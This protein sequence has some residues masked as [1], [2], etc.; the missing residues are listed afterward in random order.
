MPKHNFK[1][2]T[3]QKFGRL[4]VLDRAPNN[5]QGGSMWKCV[6]SCGSPENPKLTVVRGAELLR[7]G[8]TSCGCRLQRPHDSM[9]KFVKAQTEQN[10]ID[11]EDRA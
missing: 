1:D 6:C 11:S 8:S 4:T 5:R 2:L 7:G 3:G 9:G 10:G